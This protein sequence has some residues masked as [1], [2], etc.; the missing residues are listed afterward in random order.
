MLIGPFGVSRSQIAAAL[1]QHLQQAKEKLDLVTAMTRLDKYRVLIID[2]IGY[3][4][5]T[6]SETQAL[7]GFIPHRYES[8]N[9]I[10]T[11]NRPFSQ[12][13]QIFLDTM[14]T[15]AAIDQIIHHAT[16]SEIDSESDRRKSQKKS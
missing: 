12:W 13:D 1:V 7:F 6:V 3:V 16:I 2:D 14:M 9:L 10:I 8:G 4:K 5:K 11:S 15:V